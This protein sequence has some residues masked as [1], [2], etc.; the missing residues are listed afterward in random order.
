[1]KPDSPCGIVAVNRFAVTE[2]GRTYRGF[3][4]V[5]WPDAPKEIVERFMLPL[6]E[7]D[8]ARATV[9]SLDSNCE[10]IYVFEH[11]IEFSSPPGFVFLGYDVGLF[12]NS[13]NVF[14]FII[15]EKNYKNSFHIDDLNE[16]YL[17]RNIHKALDFCTDRL[18]ASDLANPALEHIDMTDTRG[19]FCIFSIPAS[20]SPGADK[21]HNPH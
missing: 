8:M 2:F 17:F 13:Y 6:A 15:Q 7:I 12:D 1:M 10:L 21:R 3:D 18:R 20:L 14:S 5:I 4:R 16:N 19:V 11:N 9:A